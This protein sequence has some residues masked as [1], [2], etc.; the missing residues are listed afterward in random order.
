MKVLLLFILFII[1]LYYSINLKILNVDNFSSYNTKN[2]NKNNNL[3]LAIHTVFLPQENTYFLEEWLKYHIHIGFSKF[4]LYDN[5]KSS[6][7]KNIAVEKFQKKNKYKINFNEIFDDKEH[8][9]KIYNQILEKYKDYI[10][11]IKWQPRNKDNKIYYG[12]NTSITEYIKKYKNDNDWTAFIDID[13]F[14]ILKDENF[15]NLKDFI[16]NKQNQGYNKLILTQKKMIDRFSDLNA[17]IFDLNDSIKV[18]TNGWG[19]KSICK[20]NDLSDE[21]KGG[22][23]NIH[24]IKVI[25]QKYLKLDDNVL[26]FNHYNLNNSQYNWM[27]NYFNK[28]IFESQ[29]NNDLVKF[30]EKLYDENI[31]KYRS[32]NKNYKTIMKDLSYKF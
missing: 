16:S 11:Y 18:N 1:L 2:I 19:E 7:D 3:K 29:K 31:L 15:N 4:Y 27:K 14:I 23:F 5:D 13:E 32:F 12:Q 8:Q 24:N 20:N 22:K 21:N 17:S 30:K 10:V 9:Q 28:N 6:E 25:N 26:Y